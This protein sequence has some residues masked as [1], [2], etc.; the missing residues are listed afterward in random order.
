[1]IVA[2]ND[3]LHSRSVF[4]HEIATERINDKASGDYTSLFLHRNGMAR[5]LFP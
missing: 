3:D 5:D 2:S 1:M 4:A